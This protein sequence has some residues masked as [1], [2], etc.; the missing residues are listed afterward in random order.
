MKFLGSR[1][2]FIVG[3]TYRFGWKGKNYLH[4]VTL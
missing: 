1:E 2:Q 3:F 4:G